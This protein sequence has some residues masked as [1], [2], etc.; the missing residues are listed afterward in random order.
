MNKPNGTQKALALFLAA[1]FIMACGA[2]ALAT[3][4][5][6]DTP[7]SNPSPTLSPTPTLT[8]FQPETFT[9]A[10]TI[11][12]TGCPAPEVVESALRDAAQTASD[13]G[14]AHNWSAKDTLKV[15]SQIDTSG[16]PD[17]QF[18]CLYVVTLWE[19]GQADKYRNAE[20]YTENDLLALLSIAR[21]YQSDA[22]LGLGQW[23]QPGNWMKQVN[24]MEELSESKIYGGIL[25]YF[26]LL[27]NKPTE[28]PPS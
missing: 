26:G 8:P 25:L 7:R 5:P 21:A 19:H 10:P 23:Q 15:V 13:N 1:L 6:S 17:R 16:N 28:T 20:K 27:V 12:V 22:Y 4:S 2:P 14:S 24:K 11:A 18:E 9:P 3:P